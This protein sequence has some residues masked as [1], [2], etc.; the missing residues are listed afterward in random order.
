MRDLLNILL[1]A[2]DDGGAGGGAGDGGDGGAGDAAAAAAAG[3]GDAG[4]GG[5]GAGDGGDPAAFYRPEGLPDSMVSKDERETMDKMAKAY[6]AHKE[7]EASTAGSSK[8]GQPAAASAK[9]SLQQQT[10]AASK[11]PSQTS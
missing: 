6:A 10:L 1:F 2:A 3:A 5:G 7:S 8:A 11:K 9:R 4:K